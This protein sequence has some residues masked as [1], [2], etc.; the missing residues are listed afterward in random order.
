MKKLILSLAFVTV[1]IG[2]QAGE[3]TKAEKATGASCCAKSEATAACCAGKSA[4]SCSGAKVVM[5]PK[6]AEQVRKS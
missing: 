1:A 4:A 3:G 6:A 2:L 5:S